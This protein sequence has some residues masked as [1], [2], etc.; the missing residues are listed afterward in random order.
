MFGYV[1]SGS[2]LSGSYCKKKSHT[3]GELRAD[4]IGQKVSLCGWLQHKRIDGYFV[5]MR[6]AYGVTQVTLP[7]QKVCY[8]QERESFCARLRSK[9]AALD[10]R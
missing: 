9:C 5:T 6:D 7:E 1:F 3:C 10:V 8:Y 2:R 4:D